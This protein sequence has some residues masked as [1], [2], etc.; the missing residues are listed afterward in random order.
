MT[1]AAPAWALLR[2]GDALALLILLPPALAFILPNEMQV[3]AW[4]VGVAGAIVIAIIVLGTFWRHSLEMMS[5]YLARYEAKWAALIRALQ[6]GLLHIK[7]RSRIAWSGAIS[8]LIV[9]LNILVSL[10]SLWC[11]KLPVS[12]LTGA[13]IAVIA[14]AVSTLPFRPP[15]GIGLQES[16]WAGLLVLTGLGNEQAFAGALSIR[17]TQIAIIAAETLIATA[18][19]L[20]LTRSRLQSLTGR[21]N[22]KGLNANIPAC[23]PKEPKSN[24][25]QR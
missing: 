5:S 13:A 11:L 1:V 7:S 12:F 4:A 22:S 2:V 18:I 8:I 9:A 16:V 19:I 24:Y 3:T 23:K 6:I 21:A 10:Y 20:P 14:Q 17:A 25:S 15:L